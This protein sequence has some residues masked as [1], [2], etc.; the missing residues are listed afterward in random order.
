[1]PEKLKGIRHMGVLILLA[2]LA[3]AV[4]LMG[5]LP[6]AE[7]LEGRMARVLSQ[8]RGAGG[9]SVLLRGDGENVTGAVIVADGAGSVRVML[10]LQRA[11]QALLGLEAE[12]VEVLEKGDGR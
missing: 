6:G 12:N 4:L 2:L 8:V 5:R 1:M 7:D 11:A 9:V 3:A 10:E